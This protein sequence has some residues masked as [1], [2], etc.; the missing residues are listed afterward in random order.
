M[1]ALAAR[2][3]VS[4]RFG[5]L[6]A[7]SELSLAGRAGRSARPDR[8]ERRRQIDA[9]RLHYRRAAHRCRHHPLS[10]QRYP[11]PAAA[12]ARAT[13][14]RRTFQKVRLARSAHRLRK[15][16]GRAGE[17][18]VRACAADGSRCSRPLSAAGVA[19]AV[20]RTLERVG[21]ARCGRHGREVAAVR[22]APFRRDRARASCRTEAAAAR[23][24]RDR[25]DRA[26]ARTARR[27]GRRTLRRRAARIVLVEHDLALVGRLCDRV[28]VINQGQHDLH[29]HAGGGAER[30]GGR[31]RPISA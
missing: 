7:L 3:G 26:R 15:R 22:P 24:A 27:A 20:N 21:L 9:G 30:S 31:A 10:G 29:R 1:S 23:R 2:C 18:L 6:Q 14:H 25:P 4:K 17:P 11:A 28:T 19:Q 12:P 5:G 8:T 16:R 13:R